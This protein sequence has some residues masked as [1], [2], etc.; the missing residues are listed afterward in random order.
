MLKKAKRLKSHQQGGGGIID[1]D[2]TKAMMRALPPAPPG[3]PP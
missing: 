3:G 1:A 2:V